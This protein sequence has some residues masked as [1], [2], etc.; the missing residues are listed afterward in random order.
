MELNV[1]PFE[2]TLKSFDYNSKSIGN[3]PLYI[4]TEAPVYNDVE[5]KR[6]QLSDSN[7]SDSILPQIKREV[8]VDDHV[9]SCNETSSNSPDVLCNSK[10]EMSGIHERRNRFIHKD[11]SFASANVQLENLSE[12]TEPS[13]NTFNLVKLE[14]VR[15]CEIQANDCKTS[16]HTLNTS[17]GILPAR[18][19]AEVLEVG[20]IGYR[21]TL[22]EYEVEFS[23]PVLR[24]DCAKRNISSDGL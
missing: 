14:V 19:K 6:E 22:P 11:S 17:V 7:S 18:V 2:A 10:Q 24:E 9:D 12:F 8:I 1:E 15:Q 4:K 13:T 5:V 23:V 20:Q 16:C 3:C 21:C